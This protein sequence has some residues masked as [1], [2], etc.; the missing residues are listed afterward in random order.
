[1]SYSENRRRPRLVDRQFQ[2]GLAW[3]MMFVF[4]LFFLLGIV[5]LFAPSMYVLATSRDLSVVEPAAREF[6]VL[7]R[8]VWPAVL[9]VFGGVFAY[10]LVFSHRIAGPIHRINAIL[11]GMLNGK[12]PEKI[13]LRRRDFFRTTAELIESLSRKLAQETKKTE[14]YSGE[15]PGPVRE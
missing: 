14:S 7:H 6:L 3:R 9:L 4:F 10:T 1:M 13:T 11:R 8:R 5:V 15:T 2:L 12:Y